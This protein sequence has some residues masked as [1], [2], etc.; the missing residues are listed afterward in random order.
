MIKSK[1]STGND[2]LKRGNKKGKVTPKII[3]I[4]ELSKHFM[5]PRQAIQLTVAGSIQVQES[6]VRH[7]NCMRTNN[8]QL[9]VVSESVEL[10]VSLDTLYK[11][12]NI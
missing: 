5:D 7:I 9:S 3:K 6:I 10:K 1:I 2:E 8:T 12:Q 4:S 11:M